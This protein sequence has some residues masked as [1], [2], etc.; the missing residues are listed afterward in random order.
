[1]SKLKFIDALRGL[2]ILGVIINHAARDIEVLHFLGKDVHLSSWVY[3]LS[4]QGARGVQLFFVISAFTL[5]LSH[6][7]R[8]DEKNPFLNFVIRRFFRIAPLFYTAFF[9]Y[10]LMPV[11]R[12]K[13]DLPS[14]GHIMSTLTFTNGWNPYWINAANAIVPGGWSVAVEMMFYLLFPYLFSKVKSIKQV[15]S[16]TAITLVASQLL[17][18]RLK[19]NPLITEQGTW[20]IFTKLWFPNQIPIFFLGFLVYFIFKTTNQ[21]KT[22]SSQAEEPAL[23]KSGYNRN[24]PE[25]LLWISMGLWFLLPFFEHPLIPIHFAYGITF[26]LV[27]ISLHLKPSKIIVNKFFCGLGVLSFSGYLTHFYILEAVNKILHKISLNTL[28][29]DLYFL[30]LTLLSIPVVMGV[31]HLTYRFIELPGQVLGRQIIQRFETQS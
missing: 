17:F 9:F 14:V 8:R 7:R 25:L 31:S 29:A 2:A 16:L 10:T 28:P 3:T 6:E 30:L 13:K 19:S 1:M 24:F 5:C 22:I 12:M 21:P 4:E 27:A 18:F 11:L 23:E 15:L 26:L 20:E